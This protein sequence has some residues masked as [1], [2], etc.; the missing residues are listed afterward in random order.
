MLYTKDGK[1]A[2]C[3]TCGK[4]RQSC[5]IHANCVGH[6]KLDDNLATDVVLDSS[7]NDHHGTLH[8]DDGTATTEAHHVTGKLSGGQEFD[9]T[10]DHVRVAHHSDFDFGKDDAFSIAYWIKQGSPWG[11]GAGFTIIGKRGADATP[12]GYLVEGDTNTGKIRFRLTND[13]DFNQI[14]VEG[15]TNVCDDSW[16]LV[17]CT[18]DGSSGASGALVY[19]DGSEDSTDI[20]LDGLTGSIDNTEPLCFG[21][22]YN[23]DGL[24]EETICKLDNIIAFDKELTADEVTELWNNGD[25]RVMIS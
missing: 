24:S 14:L 6:W 9:G 25:G 15:S 3:I 5:P 18:Y 19:I 22:L 4:L 1:L 10:D 16:H 11:V 21:G 7:G 17:I 2:V 12:Q 8:D 13:D 20:V 23:S